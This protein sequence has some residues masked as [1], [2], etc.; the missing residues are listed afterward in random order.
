[1]LLETLTKQEE[2]QFEDDGVWNLAMAGATCLDLVARCVGNDVVD[3]VMPFVQRNVASA[4]WR[5]REA[6]VFAFGSILDGPDPDKISS[7]FT[8][9]SFKFLLNMLKDAD[10]KVRDSTAWTL[11]RIIEFLGGAEV[12]APLITPELLPAVLA[13]LLDC[14]NVRAPGVAAFSPRR[15]HPLFFLPVPCAVS[16]APRLG[17]P[18]ALNLN[19]RIKTSQPLVLPPY[20]SAGPEAQR[21]EQGLL[22]APEPEQRLRARVER[23]DG[24][25]LAVPAERP[26]GAP[27]H[28]GPPGAPPGHVLSLP[29]DHVQALAHTQR[30]PPPHAPDEIP[31]LAP[32]QH[33]PQDCP[34]GRLRTTAYE[35]LNAVIVN[36]SLDSC[37]FAAQLIPVVLTKIQATFTMPAGTNE[38]QQRQAEL[39]GLLC[40]NLQVIVMKLNP[41]VVKKAANLTEEQ[42]K[43]LQAACQEMLKLA[44]N[45][46][47]ALLAVINC[48]SATVHEE[49]LLAIGALADACEGGFEKYMQ[50]LFPVL[51]TGLKN[52]EQY[53]VCIV[54][55]GVIGD[56][57]RALEKK[58]LP[59]CDAIVTVLL[60][61]LQSNELHKSVK[62]AILAVFGDIA[63]GLGGGFA[64]YLSYAAG[65]LQSA[66]EHAVVTG[67]QV[68]PEDE[69]AVE[70]N[71]ELRNGILEAYT[72]IVQARSACRSPS[73]ATCALSRRHLRQSIR[74]G[75]PLTGP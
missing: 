27:R 5:E 2:D 73:A 72:G 25:P 57:C 38:Q 42:S 18:V 51:Q 6:A 46:M 65:M 62:P 63:L 55:V 59:F 20:V 4:N 21:G 50:A 22:G 12:K 28:G 48:R 31:P 37:T 34:D 66:A 67:K 19:N 15:N 9:E 1:M 54:T 17:P 3:A 69:E 60:E 10:F 58:L 36:S 45:M 52:Y 32:P 68:D 61:N 14:L 44:D 8:P 35:T 23:P 26:P 39:Q 33:L 49:A 53:Q 75:M 74:C 41:R 29:A 7:V 70:Y 13:L 30:A 24:L 64:K 11:G 16:F 40:G 43:A 47:H 71:N 56:L